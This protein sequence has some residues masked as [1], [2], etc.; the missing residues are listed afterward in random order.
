MTGI[1]KKKS[2]LLK[3]IILIVI[4]TVFLINTLFDVNL[5]IFWKI[6]ARAWPLAIIVPGVFHVLGAYTKKE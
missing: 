6:L 1:T 5:E 2:E 3:G 4:G